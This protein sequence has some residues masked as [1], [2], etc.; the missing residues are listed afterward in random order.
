MITEHIQSELALE[1]SC[2]II[3][4]EPREASA[5]TNS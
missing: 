3:M 5:V 4:P 2:M 1:F